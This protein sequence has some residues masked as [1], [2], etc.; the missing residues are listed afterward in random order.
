[1]AY[2]GNVTF[3]NLPIGTGIRT[4]F[5]SYY[6]SPVILPSAT[7]AAVL[8]NR[9]YFQ[10]I[11]LA[12]QVVDR[13][14]I[15][16]TTGAAGNCRLGLYTN[17]GGMPNALILDCGTV[18]TTSI[19]TVEASFTALRLPPAWVWLAAVFDATP[20]CR[21]GSAT[22]ADILGTSAVGGVNRSISAAF[23]YGTLP[24]TATTPTAF[25]AQ[26]AAVFLRKS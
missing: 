9:V 20:T 7:A 6:M 3:T 26:A 25:T 12:N 13:I 5:T 24:S 14:G 11:I 8:A 2:V 22:A 16:V 10:P 1:M 15:E 19:A 18:D 21:I 23:T 17:A 4:A